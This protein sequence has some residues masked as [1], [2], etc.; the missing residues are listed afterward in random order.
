[1]VATDRRNFALS[2]EMFPSLIMVL[3]LVAWS[4]SSPIDVSKFVWLLIV[5][6]A[7]HLILVSALDR[8]SASRPRE[9]FFPF[10]WTDCIPRV[11][12]HVPT[13]TIVVLAVKSGTKFYE[14]LMFIWPAVIVL[15][16]LEAVL[17]YAFVRRQFT[18]AD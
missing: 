5:F 9:Q 11:M 3:Y 18:I 14:I 15:L 12:V 17:A 8:C 13:L 2:R 10:G 6:V 7:A 1:M 16:L 4:A